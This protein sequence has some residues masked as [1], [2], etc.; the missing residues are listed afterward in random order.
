[1][2]ES[3]LC[4]VLAVSITVL[5]FSLP[6]LN[7]LW[8]IASQRSNHARMRQATSTTTGED[9]SYPLSACRLSRYRR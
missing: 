5:R 6:K 4:P 7:A 1:M 8:P 2:G 3:I 9:K